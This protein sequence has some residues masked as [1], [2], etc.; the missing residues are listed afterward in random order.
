VIKIKNPLLKKL[1]KKILKIYFGKVTIK[2]YY[3]E[4]DGIKNI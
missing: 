2:L 4:V 1:P 3:F